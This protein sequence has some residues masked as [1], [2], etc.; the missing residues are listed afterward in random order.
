MSPVAPM[1]RLVAAVRGTAP[2]GKLRYVLREVDLD[3]YR[4]ETLGILGRNGAGKTTLL[5][6]L[7]GVLAPTAG[8]II[9]NTR[10]AV[11]LELGAGFDQNL[12]GRENTRVY[13]SLMGVPRTEAERRLAEVEEFA[14]IGEYFDLP[15]RTYSSGMYA[16]VAFAA[17]IHVQADLIIVDE[18][19]AVGDAS[20]RIKCYLAIERLQ[21]SGKSFLLVSHNQNLIANFCTRA[22]V[23]EKGR[24]LFDGAPIDAVNAYKQVRLAAEAKAAKVTAT[25]GADMRGLAERDDDD[26]SGRVRVGNFSFE[27][28]RDPRSGRGEGVIRARITALDDLPHPVF[29][30]VIRNG[31]GILM[32]G[33]FS[34]EDTAPLPALR[35]GESVAIESRFENLLMPGA[36]FV[37]VTI[38]EMVGDVRRPIALLDNCLRLDIIGGKGG[39]GLIDLHFSMSVDA[40]HQPEAP[41]AVADQ[42]R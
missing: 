31:N 38:W 19:L 21:K 37:G 10:I 30:L 23:I 5:A 22:M 35:R 15:A 1:A 20:F 16:R 14:D 40:E 27:Q 28:R 26:L 32:S 42:R 8:E 12:T 29:N 17:A 11:L 7:G 9:R 36:Y 2:D 24:K 13:F 3:V 18:T 25:P 39:H 41:L 4:G 34:G 6:M 33:F